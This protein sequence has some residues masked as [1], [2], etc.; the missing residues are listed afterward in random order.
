MFG[1]MLCAISLVSVI[2]VPEAH[3]SPR[4]LKGW[5]ATVPGGSLRVEPARPTGCLGP[6][7]GEGVMLASQTKGKSTLKWRTD[8]FALREQVYLHKNGVYLV[9][10]G[11]GGNL[12]LKEQHDGLL[13]YKNGE[14]IRR[15]STQELI[16]DASKVRFRKALPKGCVRS[17]QFFKTIDGFKGGH[18]KVQTVD[19]SQLSFDFRTGTLKAR[20]PA[21]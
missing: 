12:E 2:L 18:F 16:Q 14:L 11:A 1:R 19:G 8:W 20:T 9:R 6:F 4:V 3:S 13:F 21:K 10:V 7:K 15:Y 17:Y 5:T